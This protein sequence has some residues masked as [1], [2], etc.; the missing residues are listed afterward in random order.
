[1]AALPSAVQDLA[2]FFLNLAGSSSLGAVGG[3][4]G[5]AASA[6]GVGSAVPSGSC[7][8]EWSSS[9]FR[10]CARLVRP[11]AASGDLTLQQASPS[12]VQRWGP[13]ERRRSILGVGLLPLVFLLATGRGPI[14][15]PR[16]LLTMPEPGLLLPELDVRLEVLM[17]I[18]APLRRVTARIVLDLRVGRRGR[19]QEQSGIAQVAVVDPPRFRVWRMMTVPVP[20]M[21]WTLTGMILS[22]LSWAS[23][24]AS[25][26]WK[27]QQVSHKL[28]ARLLLH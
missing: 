27:S 10:C 18:L 3:V 7:W 25:T 21:R 2:R 15:H 20:L 11:S 26:A 9:C 4:V 23:S 1:M 19:P 28:D 13:V 24:G 14:G 22:S 6:S 8:C 12:L 17:G 16:S 5:K